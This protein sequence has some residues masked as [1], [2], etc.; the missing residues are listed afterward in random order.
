MTSP[1]HP[2]YRTEEEIAEHKAL[3]TAEAVARKLEG[4][5]EPKVVDSF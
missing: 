2:P 4:L 1:F 5:T 3:R